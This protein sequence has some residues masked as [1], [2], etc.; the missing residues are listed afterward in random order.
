MKSKQQNSGNKPAGGLGSRVVKEVPQRLGQKPTGVNP[1]A[2]AQ[3]GSS[4][5]NHATE[6]GSN[7]KYRGESYR[8]KTPISVPL[9]N[10]LA[11]NVGKGGPG[12]GRTVAHS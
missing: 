12:T 1:G 7:L 9:G 3:F 2:V 10:Q 11:T 4:I 5:G 8:E 6:S